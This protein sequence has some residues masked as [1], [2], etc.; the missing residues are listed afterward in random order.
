MPEQRVSLID[1]KLLQRRRAIHTPL[2]RARFSGLHVFGKVCVLSH[3]RSM[4]RTTSMLRLDDFLTV[5]EAAGF[6]GVS[7]NTIRNWGREAKIPERRHPIN[8][9][10]LYKQA[11]L[12]RLLRKLDRPSNKARKPPRAR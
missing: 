6:L 4:E 10:R 8:N 11:D 2:G 9:Y 3:C 7:A 5:H 1:G 12:A